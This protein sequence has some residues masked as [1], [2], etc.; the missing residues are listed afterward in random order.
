[1]K[2]VFILFLVC[3]LLAK[4]GISQW[5]HVN[6]TSQ[7]S[8]NFVKIDES[9]GVCIAGGTE[10]IKSLDNGDTWQTITSSSFTNVY[11]VTGA[12][13]MSPSTYLVAHNT[14][15]QRKISRTTNGGVTWTNVFA[16][17]GSFN[18]IAYNGSVLLAVGY[19]GTI[20]KS[21]NGGT[22]WTSVVS[23]TTKD[24]YTVEWDA[25]QNQWIIGGNL[26]RLTFNGINPTSFNAT[27]INYEIKD[28]SFRNGKLI[29]S[30]KY[31]TN[32]SVVEY[33]G[34]GLVTSETFNNLSSI[35]NGYFINTNKIVTNSFYHF[36]EIHP[37]DNN[38]YQYVDT[39]INNTETQGTEIW[40]MDFCSSYGLA[41]GPFG[42]LA[43]YDLNEV[44]DLIA[45]PEFVLSQIQNC[46]G[47]QFTAIPL[48]LGADSYQ[49]YIDNQLVSTND[50][51]F[52]PQPSSSGN[53]SVKLV[54]TYNGYPT[55]FNSLVYTIPPLAVPQ[56]NF[57]VDTT[58]CYLQQAIFQINGSTPLNSP[59]NIQVLHNGTIVTGP[60]SVIGNPSIN[61]I[62]LSESDTLQ[63]QLFAVGTCDTYYDTH[64]FHF[65]VVPNLGNLTI[66]SADTAICQMNDSQIN[67]SISNTL[68]GASYQ[69]YYHLNSPPIANIIGSGSDTI[70]FSFSGDNFYT[71]GPWGSDEYQYYEYPN[72]NDQIYVSA[73]YQGCSIIG[74][75][76]H[77][78]NIVYT[79]AYFD[80]THHTT[81][82]GDTMNIANHHDGDYFNWSID[83]PVFLA[84]NLNDT[85]PLFISNIPGKYEITLVSESRYGCV[86]SSS[87]IHKVALPIDLDDHSISFSEK[88]PTMKIL[89]SKMSP[90][91]YYYEY[92]YY[93]VCC[94][95][96]T[97]FC[98]RKLDANGQL[99]WEKRPPLLYDKTH[100]ISS[101]DIDADENIYATFFL[102]DALNFEL[103]HYDGGMGGY[104]SY[105]V[106][107]DSTG[108]MILAK[109]FVVQL[110]TDIL[111]QNNQLHIASLHNVYTTDLNF[112]LIHVSNIT[113]VY[114]GILNPNYGSNGE[115]LNEWRWNPRYPKLAKLKNGKIV[116]IGYSLSNLSGTITLDNLAALHP[117]APNSSS[118]AS[119]YI[120]AAIY[121]PINGF[122]SREKITETTMGLSFK[123]VT[124]DEEDNIYILTNETY[125]ENNQIDFYDSLFMLSPNYNLGT[126]YLIKV[127]STFDPIWIKETSIINGSI[128]Y[129]IPNQEIVLTG[130]V[131][132]D[133]YLGSDTEFQSINCTNQSGITGYPYSDQ[134]VSHMIYE[135]VIAYI[136]KNGHVIKGQ[137]FEKVSGTPGYVNT[138]CVNNSINACGDVYLSHQDQPVNSFFT[139]PYTYTPNPSSYKVDSLLYLA[140][141]NL[142]FKFSSTNDINQC[143]YLILSENPFHT[144]CSSDT[145][146]QIPIY[147]SN[148]VDSVAF[149]TQLNGNTISEGFFTI[150]SG[151]IQ[152]H[153]SSVDTEYS[154]ILLYPT[155][156][157]LIDT[158]TTQVVTPQMPLDTNYFTAECNQNFLLTVDSELFQ[159]IYWSQNGSVFN[160]GDSNNFFVYQSNATSTVNQYFIS[161]F[162][163]NG[164]H[165]NQSFEINYDCVPHY[166]L[167]LQSTYCSTNN[168]FQLPVE[169]TNNQ[170][171]I[172]SVAYV[173]LQGNT[174]V[175][176]GTY[177]ISGGFIQAI[178][179]QT[180]TVYSIV[181]YTANWQVIDTIVT[182]VKA[183]L[184][185]LALDYYYLTC[186]R[187]LELSVDSA[188]FDNVIW[189]FSGAVTNQANVYSIDFSN[190]LFNQLQSDNNYYFS[191][192]ALDSNGCNSVDTYQIEFCTDT[193]LAVK[194]NTS[195]VLQLHPN[196]ATTSLNITSNQHFDGLTTVIYDLNGRVIKTAE[197]HHDEAVNLE[198]S[199]LSA[200]YYMLH[201]RLDNEATSI[202]TPFIKE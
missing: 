8:L 113:G 172:T 15:T 69:F 187:D 165:I 89:G 29:E 180:N 190:P 75:P 25:N 114:D 164:C 4:S 194:E 50:T 90:K 37:Q 49:W 155:D 32:E 195:L 123:D 92:G 119:D 26:R 88:L 107:W 100:V 159:S 96:N 177:Q 112:N 197:F 200:G 168:E 84:Q 192:T 73:S 143:T 28:L 38:I 185:L 103:I 35:E 152:A 77:T 158:I 45:S 63:L 9:S 105:L 129:S 55:I 10:F 62:Q 148:N 82:I 2:S 161:A 68:I 31:V 6:S 44:P 126:S 65:S 58:L 147:V 56:Y 83:E 51:L 98:L 110:L 202:I 36:Y 116:M 81:Q 111:V 157:T 97:S 34:S 3:I 132:S 145:N 20:Y 21:I 22:T 30:R 133:F 17:N 33:D 66:V 80:F 79:D 47:S 1:M 94:P 41:V 93:G 70:N 171:P 179:P 24:L 162:D 141:S 175:G 134:I 76:I 71:W 74:H 40:D 186:A 108:Q 13:I 87:R 131:Y 91:G 144:S 135:P 199:E 189:N 109:K 166:E 85:V 7:Y 146:F 174:I 125:N 169:I 18:D 198:I 43:K 153:V 184:E 106:K 149:I 188:S 139:P 52:Y 128:N 27:T 120:Y 196:P 67:M 39:L 182:Q 14:A 178:L 191:I 19:A 176:S 102:Y 101:I 95:N 183:P 156:L 181:L 193:I 57:T 170:T 99:L 23:G 136:D 115:S 59:W 137:T 142:L 5:N 127:N 54:L 46:P 60:F 72:S 138:I 118:Y 140:D 86:D 64:D 104:Y 16:T 124:I 12:V 150:E 61:S 53:H 48:S 201:I 42:A 154:I 151:F 122:T 11:S 160:S 117:E 121:D 130:Q 167:G 173:L 163:T 78:F